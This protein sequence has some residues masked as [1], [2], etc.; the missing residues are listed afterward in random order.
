MEINEKI[1]FMSTVDKKKMLL[2]YIDTGDKHLLN[3]LYEAVQSY[4]NQKHLDAMILEGEKDIAEGRT[5]KHSEVRNMM[6]KW[7]RE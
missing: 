1:Q 7:T 4:V 5:H 3:Y 2:K 6:E